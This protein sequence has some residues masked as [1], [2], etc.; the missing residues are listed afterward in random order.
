MTT[1]YMSRRR[2]IGAVGRLL[3]GRRLPVRRKL[4]LTALVREH[5]SSRGVGVG[6]LF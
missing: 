3:R 2:R 1:T 6:L 5:L 4:T